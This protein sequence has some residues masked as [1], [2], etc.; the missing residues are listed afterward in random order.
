MA[1]QYG[2]LDKREQ[3]FKKEFE[4]K[5]SRFKYHNGFND[6]DS[7]F[8]S[9][10]RVCGHKQERH[11]QCLRR[12]KNFKC[13]KCLEH[14]KELRRV[15]SK[16]QV[17]LDKQTKRIM[18]KVINE[19]KKEVGIKL[20]TKERNCLKCGSVFETTTRTKFCSKS[21]A[22]RYRDKVKELKRR[23]RTFINGDCDEISLERLIER[24]KNV[25]YI[26]KTEC[27]KEDYTITNE[28]H[29]IVGK[30]YPSIEHVV[31]ISKGGTHTWDN[32]KLAHHYCNTIKSNNDFFAEN[33]NQLTFSI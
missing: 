25:C 26:C 13:T 17:M 5:F 27:N 3:R 6:I 10:C 18:R 19:T 4:T 28:G 15:L 11:A 16:A 29:F 12:N 22:S 14:R 7:M 30:N 23:H 33:T 31:S 8:I 9:E 21:C 32:V 2:D 1:N 20:R 24:E